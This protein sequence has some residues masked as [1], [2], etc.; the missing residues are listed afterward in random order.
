MGWADSD[1]CRTTA[2]RFGAGRCVLRLGPGRIANC[3]A[4]PLIAKGATD[5]FRHLH[6]LLA[7]PA[8]QLAEIHSRQ[9]F[10]QRQRHLH[11][12]VVRTCDKHFGRSA[13][14]FPKGNSHGAMW[15]LGHDMRERHWQ[16]LDADERLANLGL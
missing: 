8:L 6:H 16:V 7:G 15:E 12:I 1:G 9:D 10:A 14:Q 3:Q 11:G 4:F 13:A 2:F 5:L